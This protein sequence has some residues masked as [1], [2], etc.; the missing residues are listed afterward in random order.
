MRTAATAHRLRSGPPC[1][2]APAP[3]CAE[4]F[5]AGAGDAWFVGDFGTIARFDGK[6][7]SS[8]SAGSFAN[9][10]AISG[11]GPRDIWV[12][13]DEILHNERAG[14]GSGA[15]PHAAIAVSVFSAARTNAWA[16]GTGGTILRLGGSDASGWATV[17]SSTIA[18]LRGVWG[19]GD[20][21]VLVSSAPRA[22]CSGC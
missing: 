13:G 1:P 16:V 8:L 12:V 18:W 11:S 21:V 7:W 3:V 14:L 17:G 4:P 9:R 5:R 19:S 15:E 10:L 6:S 22:P 20:S 2:R